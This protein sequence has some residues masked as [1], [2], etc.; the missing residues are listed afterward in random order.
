MDDIRI[1][2]YFRGEIAPGHSL[3]AVRERLKTLF[4]IDDARIDVLFFGR[5]VPIRRNLDAD[6]ARRYQQTLGQAGALVELRPAEN[7]GSAGQPLAPAVPPPTAARAPAVPHPAD[8]STAATEWT[9]TPLGADLLNPEERAQAVAAVVPGDFQIEPAG[10]DL[11]HPQERRPWKVAAI[12]T[13]ALDLD[14]TT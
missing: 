4:K 2:V 10:V 9:L 3:T 5:P 8:G 7:A 1:D 6:T 14:S 11:L 12:D 13:S